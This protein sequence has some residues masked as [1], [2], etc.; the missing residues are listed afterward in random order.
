MYDD[1]N[2][3]AKI[4]RKEIP[5]EIIAENEYAMSFHNIAPYT[6]VHALVIPRGKY[7]DILD[8][9]THAS[10]AEQAGFWRLFAETAA[11]LGISGNFNAAAN[12]GADAPLSKQTIFHFHI[13]LMA[14]KLRPGKP[15]PHDF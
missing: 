8:F 3:F 12:A 14:G 13:H 5:A 11:A 7:V 10:A 6:D 2:V 1:N 9:A 15:A 4:M